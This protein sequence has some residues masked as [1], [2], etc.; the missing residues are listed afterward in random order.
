[1]QDYE[2]I[3]V[4]ALHEKLKEKIDASI[5]ICTTKEDSLFVRIEKGDVRYV[6]YFENITYDILSGS[7]S[8]KYCNVIV[9]DFKKIVLSKYFYWYLI[10]E[11]LHI[12]RAS[13][14][15]FKKGANYSMENKKFELTGEFILFFGIKLFRI[16]ALIDFGDVKSGDLGGYIENEIN[17]SHNDDAW[18][19]G[20]TKV[21]GNALVCDNAIVCGNAKVYDDVWI[22]GN[23]RV[24]GDA[25][26]CGDALIYDNGDYTTI[27]GFGTTF[28]TNTFFRCKDKRI[29]VVCGC[30][31]GTINQFR[32]QIKKTR[33]GKI[34]KEYLMIANLMEE[35][36]K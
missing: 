10:R 33:E 19:Y 29:R 5:F 8:D 36:F 35:H 24:C 30:F 23:S 21:Y 16:R 20:N 15:V 32:K 11:V 26:V 12:R 3:A 9:K 14:F 17:L 25:N 2:Y 6:K 13:L 18:V 34:A 28:R 1:M 27:K 7:F 22:Y 31:Y 4:K